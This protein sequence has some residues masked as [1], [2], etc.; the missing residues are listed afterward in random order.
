M[1]RGTSFVSSRAD[2]ASLNDVRGIVRALDSA[3]PCRPAI[4]GHFLPTGSWCCLLFLCEARG[5]LLGQVHAPSTR[6]TAASATRI[7]RVN[8]ACPFLRALP[9]LWPALPHPPPSM[10]LSPPPWQP[11]APTVTPSS[12]ISSRCRVHR[13]EST[14]ARRRLEPT[15]QC[16]SANSFA[17]P[18]HLLHHSIPQPPVVPQ[19]PRGSPPSTGLPETISSPAEHGRDLEAF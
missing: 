2:R 4:A 5:P 12:R 3:S 9:P 14:S 17:P 6:L 19:Q 8:P 7:P 18:T 10:W 13:R 15:D 16:S 1:F 11:S